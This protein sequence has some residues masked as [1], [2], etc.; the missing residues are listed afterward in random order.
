ML[1]KKFTSV[2]NPGPI[3]FTGKLLWMKKMGLIGG[4]IVIVVVAALSYLMGN[5]NLFWNHYLVNLFF[6]M[7]LALFGYIFTSIHYA[8]NATWSTSVRRVAEG[9]TSFFIYGIVA[10]LLLGFGFAEL[11]DWKVEEIYNTFSDSKKAYLTDL[12]FYIKMAAFAALIFLLGDKIVKNS[13]SQDSNGD[14]TVHDRM[15]KVSIAFLMLFAYLFTIFCIDL[16]MAVNSQ[17]FSTMFGVYMFAGI[18]VSGYAF[19]SIV[20]VKL[21]EDGPL[22]DVTPKNVLKDLGTW[23]MGFS[24]F[25]VYIGFSQFMLIW[26][27]NL[28]GETFFYMQRFIDGWDKV[29]IMVPLLKW[30][31]PFIF[32]MPWSMRSNPKAFKIIGSMV[33]LGQ[34]IDI[35]WMVQPS[36]ENPVM[37]IITTVLL[38]IG[39]AM[40][41]IYALTNFYSKNSVLAHK[42]PKLL[43]CIN[44]EYQ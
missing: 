20:T 32:L 3:Q 24:C 25:F 44:G 4:A 9:F 15:K 17:W 18:F 37:S 42:D 26:Y 23:T 6:F 21:K 41:F 43:T 11:Y 22:K 38:F 33:L 1:G 14:S 12:M 30:I 7:G 28:P 8:S 2:E 36:F 34:W 31:A 35:L 16:I 5:S 13:I 29:Y 40:I 19:L 27:A 10:V 39:F